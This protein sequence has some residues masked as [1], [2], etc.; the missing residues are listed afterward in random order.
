MTFTLCFGINNNGFD[1]REVAIKRLNGNNWATL[2]SNLVSFCAIILEF[3]L[4]K[5]TIFA[6]T[7]LQFADRLSFGTLTLQIGLEYCNFDFG[8]VIGNHFCTS[9]RNLV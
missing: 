9:C 3:M 8:A 6:A 5:C 1:D 4:L 7:L 2:C